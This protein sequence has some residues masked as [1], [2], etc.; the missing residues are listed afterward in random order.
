MARQQWERKH[1]NFYLKVRINGTKVNYMETLNYTGTF[2]EGLDQAIY[3]AFQLKFR[4]LDEEAFGH[5]LSQN[6][7]NVEI[8]QE[9]GAIVET[10]NGSLAG[11][12][13]KWVEE[14][15]GST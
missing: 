13:E 4:L 3:R 1:G 6:E 2:R 5:Q 7:V 11:E 10:T 12:W 8:I 9:N 14:Y 15:I